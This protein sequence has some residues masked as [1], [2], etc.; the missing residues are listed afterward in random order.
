[1]RK[2]P[3][4]NNKI[5]RRSTAWDDIKGERHSAPKD[6]APAARPRAATRAERGRK[7]D[8]LSSNFDAGAERLRAAHPKGVVGVW[9]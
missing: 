1:M 5:P 9:G 8:R 3:R 4:R 6:A 7:L 2:F